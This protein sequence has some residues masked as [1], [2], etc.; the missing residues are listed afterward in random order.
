MNA[1]LVA[2]S[3][4]VAMFACRAPA[5]ANGTTN[6]IVAGA[7][8]VA[9]ALGINNYERKT[10]IKRRE[11]DEQKRRMDA[12]REWYQRKY[13]RIPTD[14]EVFVWYVNAYGVEPSGT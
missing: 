5:I 14:R 13:R 10:R 3:V 1:R 6:T 4:V 8:A 9:A 11:L 7:A 12:Y 2:A